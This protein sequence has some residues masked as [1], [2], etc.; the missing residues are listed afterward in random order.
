LLLTTNIL[1]VSLEGIFILLF[2]IFDGAA[3]LVLNYFKSKLIKVRKKIYC[4][5][6]STFEF[7]NI[8]RICEV[9]VTSVGRF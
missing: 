8:L 6:F 5:H 2:K 1:Q 7:P 3:W 4:S 9:D